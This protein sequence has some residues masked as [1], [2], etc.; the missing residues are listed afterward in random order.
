MP[1][2]RAR[3]HDG[4]IRELL[5]SDPVCEAI[6]IYLNE[7]PHA[8]DTARGIA[9]WW[10]HRGPG[11]TEEALLKLA[12]HG[13]LQPYVNGPGRIYAYTKDRGLRR[14]VSRYVK[15]LEERRENEHETVS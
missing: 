5:T 10:I 15:S 7:H 12:A 6:V 2:S 1:D 4:V 8:V 13:L 14:V 11:V 3:H 9:E